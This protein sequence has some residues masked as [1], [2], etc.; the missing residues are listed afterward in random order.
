MSIADAPIPEQRWALPK[1]DKWDIH[2]NMF[3]VWLDE[4]YDKAT[5]T[6]FGMSLEDACES[7]EL[8]DEYIDM[9]GWESD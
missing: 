3:E 6:V 4:N 8:L 1:D 5:D 9:Y 2:Y 7:E